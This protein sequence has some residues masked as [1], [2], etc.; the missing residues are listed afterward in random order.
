MRG[1]AY[2]EKSIRRFGSA[3]FVF[4][5][6][7]G[8]ETP[9]QAPG[10]SNASD[11]VNPDAANVPEDGYVLTR[12]E[13]AALPKGKCGMVLW[14]LEESR[15]A[16]VFRYILDSGGSM[17]VNNAP[18]KL[19]RVATNGAEAFG[20]TETQRFL[21]DSKSFDV[22]IT[23]RFGL[24]FD[25]GVYLERGLITVESQDGWRTVTPVAGIAGCRGL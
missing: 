13:E 15:P 19:S 21:S 24:E 12:V 18:V 20:I 2:F 25:S 1:M 6:I 9:L 3:L 23:T 16:A 7:A 22:T 4:V 11:K 14:T 10:A 17:S 8:C 5:V